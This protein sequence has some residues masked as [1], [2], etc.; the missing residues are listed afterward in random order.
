[1]NIN[2]HFIND[3]ESRMD[4]R[5][6]IP[7]DIRTKIN[8]KKSN[9]INMRADFRS[10]NQSHKYKIGETLLFRNLS[11]KNEKPIGCDRLQAQ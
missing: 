11:A 6:R 5:N 3:I 7:R 2:I 10:I 9:R 8:T 4:A 1:M